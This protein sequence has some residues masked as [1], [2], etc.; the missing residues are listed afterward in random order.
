GLVLSMV[1]NPQQAEDLTQEVLV[2]A[3]FAL[4]NFKG[5]S[6]FYT[7]LFRI[8]SN[9]C[10]DYL[11]RRPKSEIS[12]DAPLSDTDDAISGV[13]RLPAPAAENPDAAADMPSEPVELL[14][15]LPEDQRLIL[16]LRELENHSYD[17][18]A[19]IMRCNINTV[20]SRLNRA[21]EAL[22]DAFARKFGNISSA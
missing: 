5:G 21:R 13:H 18:I 9:H 7:W 11:R 2:K 4:P 12:L 10:L 6:A 22:K 17:E 19:A 8:G 1:G 16:T 3:Y 14:G 15:S 20:K